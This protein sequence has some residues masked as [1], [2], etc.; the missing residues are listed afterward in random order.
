[1]VPKLHAAITQAVNKCEE[2]CLAENGYAASMLEIQALKEIQ[3]LI[4]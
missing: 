4:K 3:I 1:M 2:D